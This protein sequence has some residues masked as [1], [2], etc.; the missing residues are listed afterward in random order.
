MGKVINKNFYDRLKAMD[1]I[2]SGNA[3]LHYE[4]AENCWYLLMD[5]L[6]ASFSKTTY[7]NTLEYLK[8]E[9]SKDNIE[10]DFFKEK[11]RHSY[12]R[13]DK[14]GEAEFVSD[15]CY[16][17]PVYAT[18][19]DILTISMVFL[20]EINGFGHSEELGNI[21]DRLSNKLGI[22]PAKIDNIVSL[23]QVT[24][25]E[26][27]HW[28][29]ELLEKIIDKETVEII[30]HPFTEEQPTRQIVSPHFLKEYNNR[31]FLLGT[32]EDSE[33]KIFA[34]DRI[35]DLMYAEGEYIPPTVTSA[36]EIFQDVIGVTIPVGEVAPETVILSFTPRRGKYVC[37]KPLHHTQKILQDNEQEIMVSINVKPNTQL[38]TEILAFGQDVK[39]IHPPSLK[40]T[41]QTIL[42]NALNQYEVE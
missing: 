41:I 27:I 3:N 12:Y 5:H 38:E 21:I 31:W 20:K 23:E 19:I 24:K 33:I 7:Y 25:L 39:V 4:K 6:G 42:T 28:L 14:D 16:A 37:T 32:N 29:N 11:G 10:I 34:L 30:Y 26:G 18:D 15:Y 40:N 22:D 1:E 36:R 9:V 8:Q 13:L 35:K 2:I 17:L